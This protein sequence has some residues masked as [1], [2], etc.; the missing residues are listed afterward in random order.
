MRY[1]QIDGNMSALFKHQEKLDQ[2]AR[3]DELI[4]K[5]AA[6]KP[7]AQEA[8][9]LIE[10]GV[11]EAAFREARMD[12]VSTDFDS[13]LLALETAIMKHAKT[14]DREKPK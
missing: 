1:T 10:E 8:T 12:I 14:Y 6:E 2:D 5:G 4:E 7:M 3:D 11:V 9:D 13:S